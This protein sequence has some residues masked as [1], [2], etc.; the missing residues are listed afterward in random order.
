[1]SE[2][3]KERHYS[4]MTQAELN[5]WDAETDAEQAEQMAAVKRPGKRKR[6]RRYV[7]APWEFFA[8]ICRLPHKGT[9]MI[10]ALL[11]YRQ[12]KVRRRQTVTL[13]G[14]ELAELGVDPR[15]KREALRNLEAA[16]IVRLHRPGPGQKTEVTLLWRPSSP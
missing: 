4:T 14:P 6:A 9:T 10:V 16:G 3:N 5:A 2:P 1:M 12:T 13:P 8:D 15:R 11:V 7:G